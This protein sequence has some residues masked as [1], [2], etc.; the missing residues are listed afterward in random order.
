MTALKRKKKR[1]I[2]KYR[3]LQFMV[4]K[5]HKDKLKEYCAYHGIT[6]NKLFR[7]S[8]REYMDRHYDVPV[9]QVVHKNQM[10]IFDLEGVAGE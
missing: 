3:K 4:S 2:V 8:L 10:S 6:L 7:R 9:K 1:K 5:I